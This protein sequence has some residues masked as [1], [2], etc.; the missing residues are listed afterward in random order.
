MT[1]GTSGAKGK[2]QEPE[3]ASAQPENLQF[4][5]LSTPVRG[6]QEVDCVKMNLDTKFNQ[7]RNM[8]M[9]HQGLRWDDRSGGYGSPAANAGYGSLG[10]SGGY[11]SIGTTK[12]NQG[13]K[14]EDFTL[15]GDKKKA[16]TEQD[17]IGIK[18]NRD[19]DQG[20]T[21]WNATD[22]MNHHKILANVDEDITFY[23]CAGR[24]TSAVA[25]KGINKI[26]RMD[27]KSRLDIRTEPWKHPSTKQERTHLLL[28]IT[29]EKISKNLKILRDD[30]VMSNFLKEGKCSMQTSRLNESVS[31][32]ILVIL[33]KDP[34]HTHR[35]SFAK[36]IE[37]HLQEHNTSHKRIP[38]NI[39]NLP[40]HGVD[41][42]ERACVMIVGSKDERNVVR[43]LKAHPVP[44]LETMPWD[45]KRT[46]KEDHAHKLKRHS[47]VVQQTKAFKVVEMEFGKIPEFRN[48]MFNTT[49]NPM[50]V[51]VSEA[52]HSWESGTVYIQYLEQ[53]KAAVLKAL[54]I[55]LN[56]YSTA[57]LLDPDA[58]ITMTVNT[59]ASKVSSKALQPSKYDALV[60]VAKW[61]ELQSK[62]PPKTV[63]V[64]RPITN[65]APKSFSQ[66]LMQDLLDDTSEDSNS[67]E[68]LDSI[69]SDDNT[70]KTVREKQLE[71]ENAMLVQELSELKQLIQE[72]G[73]AMQAQNKA[74][75][76]EISELH[77]IM[78]TM[79][80][81]MY[82]LT[83]PPHPPAMY[84]PTQSTLTAA[85]S[86]RSPSSQTPDAAVKKK[87]KGPPLRASGMHLPHYQPPPTQYLPQ[88]T[89]EPVPP[90][91]PPAHSQTK[92]AAGLANM[93]TSN[94]SVQPMDSEVIQAEIETG[95][96][97]QPPQEAPH[98][99]E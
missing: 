82:T 4:T 60:D 63:T 84:M 30:P 61:P 36:R 83:I 56:G 42:T 97:P 11:G 35:D 90:P 88:T 44:H 76:T 74:H 58:S 21:A 45:H 85:K 33:H 13:D 67:L 96:P 28:K 68:N 70:K 54:R 6:N 38:V 14:V 41:I 12:N 25:K 77:H 87:F 1:T 22:L 31:K 69:S 79:Q 98:N 24:P 91:Q 40:V 17:M 53:H 75:R 80:H 93:N 34:N 72:Q 65:P 50:L 39:A 64:S 9:N 78:K 23:D 3:M 7:E 18:I 27:W 73:A 95:S 57:K 92:V 19:G 71:E 32:S 8:E 5:E 10:G 52:D 16:V 89:Q 26:K 46:H 94:Q 47:M 20:T 49:V 62:R 51:D 2:D 59:K 29:S 86:S 37:T 48:A 55:V 43:I 99:N 66:A 15:V 81:Q